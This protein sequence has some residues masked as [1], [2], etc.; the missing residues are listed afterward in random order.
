[1]IDQ[2]DIRD[3]GIVEG[4]V[5]ET[6]YRPMEYMQIAHGCLRVIVDDGPINIE[7]RIPIEDIK[8]FLAENEAETTK[9]DHRTPREWEVCVDERQHALWIRG[10]DE[11][12]RGWIRV[13]EVLTEKGS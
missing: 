7:T 1:M 10:D 6:H 4:H 8:E 11:G 5:V 13:R 3:D 12:E 2:T 9:G